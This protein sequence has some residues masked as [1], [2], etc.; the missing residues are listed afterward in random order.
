MIKVQEV[1]LYDILPG[2]LKKDKTIAA[3]AKVLQ[4]YIDENY[5]Y[6]ERL[7]ILPNIDNIENEELID[8]LA[9]QFHVD[10]YDPLLNLKKKKKL[11]KS[12]ISHHRKKGTP[13]VVE[14]LL[15]KVFDVSKIKEWFEYNGDPFY[16]RIHTKDIL[17][18]EQKYVDTIKAL[19]TVKNTRSWL[20]KIVV[21]RDLN[22]NIYHGIAN[23]QLRTNSYYPHSIVDIK[24]T[25]HIRIGM[26]SRIAKTSNYSIN[27]IEDTKTNNKVFFACI[28]KRLKEIKMEVEH[29]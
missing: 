27:I 11:V 5:A 7:N 10:F 24:A 16:F 8:H 6:I 15:S 20:E 9:Y 12:S 1:K 29:V 13:W 28:C 18:D 4:K 21:E 2:I 3:I 26:L 19:N 25:N 17:G 23:R 14:D 22:H